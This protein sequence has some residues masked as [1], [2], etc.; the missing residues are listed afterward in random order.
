LRLNDKPIGAAFLIGFQK[1]LEIPW[2]STIKKYNSLGINMLMYW[3]I[4]K[5]AIEN[6]YQVF[7]FGR[8]SLNSGTYRFK[9]QWGA[10]PLQLYW[11]YW[12]KDGEELPKLNTSNKK[13]KFAIN[14][15]KQLPIFITNWAGPKIVKNLP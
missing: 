12:L 9:K 10:K 15:W 14:V 13:Y 4:L 11:H 5:Y 7:D 1:K 6:G 3:E 8:S 2:A